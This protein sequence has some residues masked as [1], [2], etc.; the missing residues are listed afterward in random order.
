MAYNVAIIKNM[1][2]KVVKEEKP[3]LFNSLHSFNAF[4][5][6]SLWAYHPSVI[7]FHNKYYLFYTGRGISSNRLGMGIKDN[8]GLAIS[9][10]LKSWNKIN[11]PIIQTGK[12][13]AWDSEFLAHCFVFKEKKKF[14]MLYDGSKKGNWLESIGLADSTDLIHWK[15]YDNPIFKVSKNWWEKRHVSRCCIYKLEDTFYLYYA[16]HDGQ[17]ERIGLATGKSI[18]NLKRFGKNPV[19]D[20]GNENEWDAR[21]ISDP[22]ILKYKDKYLMFYSGIDNN[23]RERMGVAFSKD[24][25]AWKKYKKPIL[26]VS[27]KSWDRISAAR[28]DIKIFND[29]IYIF[30]SG[31]RKYT[32][33]I[34]IAKISI[35]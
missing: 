31:K 15:K 12:G 6:D 30:Y 3:I 10:D 4:K 2:F 16:G 23:S 27:Q 28:S 32:Y 20:V 9:E 34:G 33:S 35:L 13:D 24:L 18:F 22:R 19:L 25:Y 5:W 29:K 17:R 11:N 21:S 7:E 14:Y 8:I 26:D 1:D